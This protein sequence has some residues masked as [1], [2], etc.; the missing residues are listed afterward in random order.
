MKALILT[1]HTDHSAENSLYALASELAIHPTITSVNVATRKTEA[2]DAFFN[3]VKPVDLWATEINQHFTYDAHPH[4]LEQDIQKVDH[5]Q[6]DFVWLRMPPPLSEKFLIYLAKIFEDKI[7]IND[8]MGIRKTGTKAFLLNFKAEC[9]PMKLCKSLQ[10]II[11]FSQEFPIVLKPLRAYGGQGIVK[12]E[13]GKIFEA[14][15]QR[16]LADFMA[17]YEK[18]PQEYLAVKYLKNVG[19]GDKR[20]IV[21]DS[22]IMGAS[23]RMPPK[24]SWICNAAMG[25][26]SFITSPAPE[27]I[28]IVTSIDPVMRAHGIVMYGIDTLVDDNGK[29]VLSE[30]NTTSVG[31]LPQIARLKGQPLVT[32]GVDLIVQNVLKRAT[33]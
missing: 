26:S 12:I 24:G 3:C 30:I 21:I 10:E 5:Q 1:D 9:P 32:K 7:I 29:R 22:H 23:L 11:A 8:P 16:K 25:G 17:Q 19:Q 4:H 13:N 31:G 6:Y 27:E 14:K 2:N 15:S 20:I 18:A 33:C 28:E